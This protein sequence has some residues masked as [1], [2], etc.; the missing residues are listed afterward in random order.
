MSV[1]AT[2]FDL[3]HPDE[4]DE[5]LA[6]LL[7]QVLR[8]EEARAKAAELGSPWV[9]QHSGVIP[10]PDH[11]R[12]GSVDLGAISAFVQDAR[13]G[14]PEEEWREEAWLPWLRLAVRTDAHP[15]EGDEAIVVLD[16][17]QVRALRDSLGR[18]LSDVEEGEGHDGTQGGG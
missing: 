10:R 9:F 2:I 3:Q 17:S 11:P 13:W 12:G 4:K 7:M 15:G 5:V 18:W 6:G 8:D 14:V 16:A 1:Y